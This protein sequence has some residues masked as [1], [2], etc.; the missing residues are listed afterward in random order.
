MA[1]IFSGLKKLFF[2]DGP[3]GRQPSGQGEAGGDCDDAQPAA[4]DA[5]RGQRQRA[6]RLRGFATKRQRADASPPA[7]VLQD[8]LFAPGGV[9]GLDWFARTLERDPHGDLAHECLEEGPDG[10]LRPVARA[11]A[12]GGGGGGGAA[13]GA[14]GGGGARV[15][16]VAAGAVSVA[17]AAAAAPAGAA[18][19]QQRR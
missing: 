18:G 7:P 8:A 10:T 15:A 3:P 6:G 1:G 13:N 11:P 5:G 16:G 9:Q 2:K 19:A 17:A 12:P 4:A 14:G